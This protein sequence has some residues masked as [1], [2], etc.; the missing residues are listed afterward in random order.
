[1]LHEIMTK[2]LQ[3]SL[4]GLKSWLL[5]RIA[6]LTRQKKVRSSM[7]AHWFRN[8]NKGFVSLIISFLTWMLTLG[9]LRVSIYLKGDWLTFVSVL[10]L[11]TAIISFFL[12]KGRTILPNLKLLMLLTQL[13]TLGYTVMFIF[14]MFMDQLDRIDHVSSVVLFIVTLAL[15]MG[16]GGYCSLP[17]DPKHP[18]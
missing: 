8:S 13:P 6:R 15:V 3:K 16:G 17:R 11:L 2:I 18:P 5:S 1:M 12:L 9:V 7:A 10:L 4:G 14:S